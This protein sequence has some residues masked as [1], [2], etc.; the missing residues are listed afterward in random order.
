[1]R[2][3]RG[4]PKIWYSRPGETCA[5]RPLDGSKNK[6]DPRP[7]PAGIQIRFIFLYDTGVVPVDALQRLSKKCTPMPL[8]KMLTPFSCGE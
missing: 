4:I 5:G 2:P 8:E 1:M 7:A 6:L 3:V